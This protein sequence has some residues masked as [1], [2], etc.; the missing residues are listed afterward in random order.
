MAATFHCSIVTPSNAV[1][2]AD[3]TYVTFQAWDGQK[4]V[5][6]GA[7]AFLTKL[8]V[9][10]ARVDLAD[11][12]QKA[13]VLDAGVAKLQDGA[14]TILTDGATLADA[15]DRAAAER[16]YTEARTKVTEPGH[17]DGEERNT[18]ERAQ[19]LAAAKLRVGKS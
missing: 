12:S 7:S 2:S 1:L 16:E 14:L 18:L 17:T 19:Q 3:A 15:I 4:G 6:H 9:G 11:G 5:M 13:F 8:G 10:T